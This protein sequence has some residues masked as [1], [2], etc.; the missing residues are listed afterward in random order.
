VSVYGTRHSL[1]EQ[2][3]ASL[4]EAF[5]RSTDMMGVFESTWEGRVGLESEV[6]QLRRGDLDALSAL[7]APWLSLSGNTALVPS[8]RW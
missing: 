7:L 3:K 8:V 5:A 1:N 4:F 2:A 6:A